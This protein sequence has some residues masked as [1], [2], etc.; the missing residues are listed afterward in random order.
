MLKKLV[1]SVILFSFLFLLLLSLNSTAVSYQIQI[2]V[3]APSS[4]AG[5]DIILFAPL[6]PSANIQSQYYVIN[7][8]GYYV[9]SYLFSTYPPYL[10]YYIAGLNNESLLLTYGTGVTSEYVTCNVFSNLFTF[11][12]L[13]TTLWNA[14]NVQADGL[15]TMGNNS[16]LYF[17]PS[18]SRYISSSVVFMYN[19]LPSSVSTN[20]FYEIA[21]V[22]PGTGVFFDYLQ[23]SQKVKIPSYYIFSGKYETIFTNCILSNNFDVEQ[24][25]F[26]KVNSAELYTKL[27]CFVKISEEGKCTIVCGTVIQGS[28]SEKPCCNI[29]TN[30]IAVYYCK[31]SCSQCIEGKASVIFTPSLIEGNC[32]YAYENGKMVN[33]GKVVCDVVVSSK[34]K[35]FV[36]YCA[37]NTSCV[38]IFGVPVGSKVIVSYSNGTSE[39]IYVSN[40][41]NN[42]GIAEDNLVIGYGSG[43]SDILIYPPCS[44]IKYDAKI[45]FTDFVRA[46]YVNICNGKAYLCVNGTVLTSLGNVTFPADVIIGVQGVGNTQYLLVQVVTDHGV[47]QF[48]SASPYTIYNVVPYIH[49]VTYSNTPLIISKIGV[50]LATGLYDEI[51]GII[52]TS[53]TSPFQACSAIINGIT[54]PGLV[55]CYSHGKLTCYRVSNSSSSLILKGM[56]GDSVTLVYQNVQEQFIVSS[57]FY[58]LDI[59]SNTPFVLAIS[60]TSRTVTVDANGIQASQPYVNKLVNLNST[61]VSSSTSLTPPPIKNPFSI[62][63]N[64][65]QLMDIIIYY[66]GGGIAIYLI[67]RNYNITG[68]LWYGLMIWSLL[69]IAIS[70]MFGL[71]AL[72]PGAVFG[73]ALAYVAKYLNR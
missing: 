50:T 33:L 26:V 28:P 39:C 60:P 71:Y 13:N 48:I 51:S 52:K 37:F 25:G 45:G 16:H 69:S 70:L 30:L 3:N 47:T 57:C 14:T 54:S 55:V 38:R 18:I 44:N 11:Y 24:S 2:T 41:V 21:N 65:N 40:K 46:Y 58:P 68:V 62:S 17:Q 29:S 22:K 1:S 6:P 66:I 20:N 27:T 67:N 5:S 12:I 61:K 53:V 19:I 73:F 8:C 9:D 43:I 49:Y 59:P 32:F 4:L 35:V 7:Q 23:T 31:P 42:V 36:A 10:V 64:S 72:L 56:D 15:L 34:P 63:I